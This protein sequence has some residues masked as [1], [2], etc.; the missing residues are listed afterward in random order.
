[1]HIGIEPSEIGRNHPT[2]IGVVA[3]AKAAFGVL[4]LTCAP[5]PPSSDRRV[6]HRGDE[7]EEITV[8][9]RADHRDSG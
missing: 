1:M 5:E 9:G 8:H 3:D 7:H 4:T 2:E 6:R